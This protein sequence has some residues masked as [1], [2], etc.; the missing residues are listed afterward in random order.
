MDQKRIE[1]VVE[2][3]EIIDTLITFSRA[4][5]TQDWDRCRTIVADT[6]IDDHGTPETLSRE[7]AI[8][9]WRLQ[10]SS[11]GCGSFRARSTEAIPIT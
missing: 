6:V 9:R 11:L 5:D 2:R 10:V 4:V 1:R 8:E 3:S 7:A